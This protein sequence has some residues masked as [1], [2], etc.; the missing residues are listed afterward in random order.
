MAKAFCTHAAAV[1]PEWRDD[2]GKDDIL[3][4]RR[5]SGKRQRK[6]HEWKWSELAGKFRHKKCIC[7]AKSKHGQAK[8]KWYKEQPV[9]QYGTCMH[10]VAME[11]VL[12]QI[13]GPTGVALYTFCASR[14]CNTGGGKG[15][16]LNDVRRRHASGQ[17]GCLRSGQEGSTLKNRTVSG[18][19]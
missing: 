9:S 18:E 16:K 13:R 15:V 14:G 11:H 3:W 10:F 17:K 2:V 6:E 12:S 1:E 7:S 8:V 4:E 19:R 5:A